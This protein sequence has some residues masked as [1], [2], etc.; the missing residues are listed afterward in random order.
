M[1]FSNAPKKDERLKLAFCHYPPSQQLSQ[2]ESSSLPGVDLLAVTMACAHLGCEATDY[3]FPFLIM[4]LALE[5]GFLTWERPF[6]RLTLGEK[7]V[8]E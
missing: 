1:Y 2:H 8:R 6:Q 3:F 7:P 5:K 4:E